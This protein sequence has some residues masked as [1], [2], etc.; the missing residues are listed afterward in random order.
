MRYLW[1]V[2]KSVL[3]VG[4]GPTTQAK[5]YTDLTFVVQ[6]DDTLADGLRAKLNGQDD[7]VPIQCAILFYSAIFRF[8]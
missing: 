5:E 4:A 7:V 6:Q 3:P 2:V 1:P 8:L